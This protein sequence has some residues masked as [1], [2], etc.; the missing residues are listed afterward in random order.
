MRAYTLHP[1]FFKLNRYIL[2]EEKLSNDA[3]KVKSKLEHCSNLRKHRVPWSEIKK[4]VG[5]SRSNYYRIK[6]LVSLYGVKGYTSRSKRPKSLRKSNIPDTVISLIL[7]LRRENP[8][9]GKAKIAIILRRD[10]NVTLSESS[11]GRVLKKLIAAGKIRRS[12]SAT[13]VRKKR[14]FD[15]HAKRWEYGKHKPTRPG[16]MVQIDHMSVVKNSTNLKH[17]QAWDPI[18]KYIGAEVYSN[19]TSYSAKNF[20]LKLIKESPFPISSVQVDGGSEFMAEFEQACKDL[21]IALYVLPPKSPK[22]NGGVE[23]G[24]RI[25]REEFYARSDILADSVGAFKY[26]LKSAVEKYNS[27]RPHKSL[28]Y[29]T[30][31]EYINSLSRS[32]SQSIIY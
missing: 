7:S 1:T 20:L 18:S 32:P 17:F 8:T 14:R 2:P 3:R 30:P 25:F 27:Y 28:D 31:L 22:F 23:R 21:G 16:E 26:E 15:S 11:V 10:H 19:A 24:N 4:I 12:L 9:Y 13:K 29:L 6:K 5:L